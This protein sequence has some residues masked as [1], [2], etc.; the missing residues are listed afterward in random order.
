[1][2]RLRSLRQAHTEP[3]WTGPA[4]VQ[5]MWFNWRRRTSVVHERALS[6]SVSQARSHDR[7]GLEELNTAVRGALPRATYVQ[8]A[9]SN[10]FV[11][12]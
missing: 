5:C 6:C 12:A 2:P 7:T 10:D 9:H 11:V 1:M 3:D 8:D 4:R